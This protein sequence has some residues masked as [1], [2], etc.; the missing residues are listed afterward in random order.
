MEP[1]TNDQFLI[2][3]SFVSS[4]KYCVAL[5]SIS[6]FSQLIY[7]IPSLNMFKI[8]YKPSFYTLHLLYQ[9]KLV[10]SVIDKTGC[11]GNADKL[12][13]NSL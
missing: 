11:Q 6:E 2:G 7:F 5:F 4:F 10:L 9:D 1:F 12:I 13:G 3:S 8:N